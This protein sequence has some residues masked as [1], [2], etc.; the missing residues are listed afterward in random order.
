MGTARP[1]PERSGIPEGFREEEGEAG[2]WVGGD[3]G[4]EE[5][6]GG[7]TSPPKSRR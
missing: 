6:N 2:R 5:Q 3:G 1:A 7:F 4:L